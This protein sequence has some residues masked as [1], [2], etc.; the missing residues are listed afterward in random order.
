[1]QEI[2]VKL[3]PLCAMIAIPLETAKN[4]SGSSNVGPD[5]PEEGWAYIAQPRPHAMFSSPGQWRQNQNPHGHHRP[6][7]QLVT[8]VSGAVVLETKA[9][10]QKYGLTPVDPSTVPSVPEPST[11]ILAAIALVALVFWRKL[12]I[13]VGMRD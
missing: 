11:L 9:Q 2:A 6:V 10:F 8:P 5:T 13:G 3:I 7:H 12:G 4:F 1:M